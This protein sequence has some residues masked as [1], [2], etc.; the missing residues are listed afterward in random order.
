LTPIHPPSGRILRSFNI[1]PHE[2]V[3]TEWIVRV[4]KRYMLVEEDLYW[5]GANGVLMW[6]IT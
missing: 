4:A 6:C 1:L 2:H 3:S 5:R